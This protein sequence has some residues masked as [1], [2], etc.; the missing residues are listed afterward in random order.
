[1]EGVTSTRGAMGLILRTFFISTYLRV[2][3]INY[4]FN[5]WQK[6]SIFLGLL[7]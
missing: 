3:C 1:M 6:S 2:A 7:T 4:L 5:T